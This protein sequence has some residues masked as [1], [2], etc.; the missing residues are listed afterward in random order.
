MAGAN[1]IDVVA[2]QDFDITAHILLC[3]GTS[4]FGVPLMAVHA[5]NHDAFTVDEH[6]FIL[7]FKTA[8]P[9]FQRDHL[10]NLPTIPLKAYIQLVHIW[11][12]G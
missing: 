10:D 8:E 4:P 11:V 1:R 2:L 6:D 5:I 12:F 3:D 9:G 7:D